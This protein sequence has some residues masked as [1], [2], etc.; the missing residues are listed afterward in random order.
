[1]ALGK[2]FQPMLP[3]FHSQQYAM[4]N[5]EIESEARQA[6]GRRG[7]DARTQSQLQMQIQTRTQMAERYS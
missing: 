6:K 3:P 7:E 2:P 5:P 4:K 1:M